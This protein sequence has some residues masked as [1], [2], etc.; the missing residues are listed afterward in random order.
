MTFE[1]VSGMFR[2]NCSVKTRK[3]RT[4]RRKQKGV[5]SMPVTKFNRHPLIKCLLERYEQKCQISVSC[6]FLFIFLRKMRLMRSVALN[7]E[8]YFAVYDFFVTTLPSKSRTSR[9]I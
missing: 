3:L 1:L 5:G 7:D 8:D 2:I 9:F 4:N 6:V